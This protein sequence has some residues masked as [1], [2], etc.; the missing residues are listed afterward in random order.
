MA[1]AAE[2]INEALER[3][4]TKPYTEDVKETHFA[5][6]QGFDAM[7]L[8]KIQKEQAV[9]MEIAKQT[10]EGTLGKPSG[11]AQGPEEM[12]VSI[13]HKTF[14]ITTPAPEKPAAA[15]GMTTLAKVGVGAALTAAGVGL[16]VAGAVAYSLLAND[17]PA[18]VAPVQPGVDTDTDTF[19]PYEFGIE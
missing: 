18:A 13:G 4:L 2:L 10:R 6:R 3:E 5:L 7:M 14:N 9:V 12:G 15:K 11:T 19:V 17:P 1:E 16:P 8:D